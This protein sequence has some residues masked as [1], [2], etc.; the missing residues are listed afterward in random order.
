LKRTGETVSHKP[1]HS[2]EIYKRTKEKPL[3]DFREME[4]C[5]LLD[6]EFKIILLKKHNEAQESTDR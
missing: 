2:R 6:K 4:I 3:T 1:Y 5:E